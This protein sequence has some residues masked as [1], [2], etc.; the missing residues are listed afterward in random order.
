MT[1]Q[2]KCQ[3]CM[4]RHDCREIYGKL[5][6]SDGSSVALSVVAAFLVPLLLFIAFLVVFEKAAGYVTEHPG[7][8]TVV[9]LFAAVGGTCIWVAA[10]RVFNRHSQ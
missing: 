10:W 1:E 4:Q 6:V 7:V 3:G 2:D 8:Q 9:G 5:G